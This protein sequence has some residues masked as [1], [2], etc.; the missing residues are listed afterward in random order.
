MPLAEDVI[1]KTAAPI[2]AAFDLV[3][4]PAWNFAIRAQFREYLGRQETIAGI[5]TIEIGRA[6]A[7]VKETG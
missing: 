1:D 3:A 7:R 6:A 4:A 2:T 5:A